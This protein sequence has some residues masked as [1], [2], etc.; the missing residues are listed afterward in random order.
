M[1]HGGDE[2]V[3]LLDNIVPFRAS[4]NIVR[5]DLKFPANN[6]SSKAEHRQVNHETGSMD[7]FYQL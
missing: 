6:N 4:L 1:G 7:Y 5:E 3:F 2:W